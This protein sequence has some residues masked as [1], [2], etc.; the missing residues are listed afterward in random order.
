MLYMNKIEIE[1]KIKGSSTQ[2]NPITEN[3]QQYK[4]TKESA[5]QLGLDFEEE[6]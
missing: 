3:S 4:I 5:K 6:E 1:V 2:A